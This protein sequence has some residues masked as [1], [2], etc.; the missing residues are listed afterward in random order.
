LENGHSNETTMRI[1]SKEQNMMKPTSRANQPS[2][3]PARLEFQPQ[4]YLERKKNF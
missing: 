1:V 4:N 3:Q 2:N